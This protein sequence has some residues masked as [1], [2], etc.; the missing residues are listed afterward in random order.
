MLLVFA[1]GDSG[2]MLVDLETRGPALDVLER[3]YSEIWRTVGR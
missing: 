3:V 1:E 2:G